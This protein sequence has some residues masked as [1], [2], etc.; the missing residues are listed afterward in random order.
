MALPMAVLFQVLGHM[1]RDQD[2]PGV[3]AIHNS[4]RDVD[5]GTR[6]VGATTYVHHAADRPAVHPHPEFELRV[7]PRGTTDLQRTFHRRFWSIV[8]DQRHPISGR[9]RDEPPICLRGT[10]MFRFAD[11]PIQQFQQPSLLGRYQ[12]GVADNVDKEH[13]GDLQF[14]L[15]AHFSRHGND[16]SRESLTPLHQSFGWDEA[17]SFWKRGSFRSGSNMGSSRSS[18]GVSA[19]VAPSALSY[20]IESSFCKAAMAR[21]GSPTCAATRARISMGPGPSNRSFSIGTAALA[22]SA[23]A[24]AAALSPRPAF[25]SARSPIKE[26]FSGCSW[27][28]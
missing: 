18:A 20:G 2:M 14:D 11:D 22:R 25:V 17:A 10:E 15:L 26:L 4:L 13:I 23:I 8:E 27:R 5:S 3:T 1:F 7:F 9:H 21:S 24:N 12:L 16:C 6:N 19:T 28:K